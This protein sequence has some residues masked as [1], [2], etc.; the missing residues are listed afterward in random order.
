LAN[1]KRAQNGF[2][3]IGWLNPALYAISRDATKYVQ[4]FYDIQ[5]GTSPAAPASQCVNSVTFSYSAGV[6]YDLVTGL[7]SPRAGLIAD[8]GTW[9][10]YPLY[11][12]GPLTTNGTS[13]KFEWA[14]QGAGATPT[15]PGP[16]RCAWADRAP[17]GSE[18]K[19]PGDFNIILGQLGQLAN[20]PRHKYMAIAV[21]RAPARDPARDNDLVVTEVFGF[22][23]PP[24]SSDPTQFP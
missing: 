24:F 9:P 4:D 21:Y 23:S 22:K 13:T 12:Q 1:Q 2:G 5:K 15:G 19:Q 10:S 8:L 16:G 14:S 17:R 18:I 7:G 6:G 3:P 20:L 11:C